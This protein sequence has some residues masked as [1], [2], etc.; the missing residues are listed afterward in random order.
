[1]RERDSKYIS[2][3]NRAAALHRTDRAGRTALHAALRV[4]EANA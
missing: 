3:F 4:G 2:R 1:M